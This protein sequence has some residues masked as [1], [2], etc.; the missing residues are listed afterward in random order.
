MSHVKTIVHEFWAT[1]INSLEATVVNFGSQ[2]HLV[3]SDSSEPREIFSWVLEITSALE[4]CKAHKVIDTQAHYAKPSNTDNS[5][6]PKMGY[7]HHIFDKYAI[8]PAFEV[9]N[10]DKCRNLSFHLL[11]RTSSSVIDKDLG[12]RCRRLLESS[13]ISQETGERQGQRLPWLGD[14][15]PH[16]DSWRILTPKSL[17]DTYSA[18]NWH[19]RL[20]VACHL[21]SF[22]TNCQSGKQHTFAPCWRT[23]HLLWPQ[24][25]GHCVTCQ[26][27]PIWILWN[28]TGE[29][30][31]RC[32][33][34]ILHG[35][36]EQQKVSP[37]E[38]LEWL[39]AGCGRWALHQWCLDGSALHKWLSV[40]VTGL[41][42]FRELW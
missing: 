13:E 10:Q 15:L 21:P 40:C 20:D 14:T 42:R 18:G 33:S 6:L 31:W 32:K 29:L 11:W 37:A 16:A 35:K 28:S 25:L 1:S 26:P 17:H 5:S 2:M 3:F 38:S 41:W 39:A 36:T 30:D 7:V 24:L 4:S 23:S 12:D 8:S 22:H 34:I 27:A 19:G 9:S